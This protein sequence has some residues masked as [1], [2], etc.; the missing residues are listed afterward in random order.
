MVPS[1]GG[2]RWWARGLCG[3]AL[4]ALVGPSDATE[5]YSD[6]SYVDSV[7]ESGGYAVACGWEPDGKKAVSGVLIGVFW[8]LN[9]RPAEFGRLMAYAAS[10]EDAAINRGCRFKSDE[11]QAHMWAIW[12]LAKRAAKAPTQR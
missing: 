2:Q 6:L 5:P 9:D 11:K 4:F 8:Y 1:F 3:V 12:Q 7:A 10:I